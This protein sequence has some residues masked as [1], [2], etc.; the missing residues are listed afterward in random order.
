[1]MRY[2]NQNLS[3]KQNVCAEKV[4]GYLDRIVCQ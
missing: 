4:A 2:E 1:M 3:Q